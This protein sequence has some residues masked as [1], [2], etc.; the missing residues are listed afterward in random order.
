LKAII[1]FE[2]VDHNIEKEIMKELLVDH[3]VE[4]LD[5]WTKGNAIITIEFETLKKEENE[6]TIK[7]S[8]LCIN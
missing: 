3:M 2:L 1:E 7:C 8:N 6:S 5:Q 4:I